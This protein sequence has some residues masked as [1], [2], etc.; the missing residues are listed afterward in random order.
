M[1]SLGAWPLALTV[2]CQLRNS[3]TPPKKQAS[4]S[5]SAPSTRN[6]EDAAEG[7]SAIGGVLGSALVATTGD[8]RSVANA[9]SE[10]LKTTR[11]HPAS[12]CGRR[13]ANPALVSRPWNRAIILFNSFETC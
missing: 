6:R 3:Q 5:A 2:R 12:H 13:R 7:N 1:L 9:E 8:V 10:K 4:T 11:R